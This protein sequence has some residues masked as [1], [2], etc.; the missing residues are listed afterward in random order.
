MATICEQDAA[1]RKPRLRVAD[2]QT[3]N[4]D[5]AKGTCRRVMRVFL[6]ANG[7]AVAIEA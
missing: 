4:S 6:A 7:E 2:A 1:V 5:V 3:I